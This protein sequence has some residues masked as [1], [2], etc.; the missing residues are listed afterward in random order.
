[1]AKWWGPNGFSN[2]FFDFEFREGGPSNFIM[3]GPDGTNYDNAIV[4]AEIVRHKKIV[5]DHVCSPLFRA[6][7]TFDNLGENT[8]VTFRQIFETVEI[9]EALRPICE[10]AN[11]QN[12]DRITALLA[13][14]SA[15]EAKDQEF[16]IMRIFDAPQTLIYKAWTD[17]AILSSWWGPETFS[18]PVCDLDVRPKGKFRIVMRGLADG[19]T[20]DYPLRGEFGEISPDRIVMIQDATE[21]PSAWHD[22]VNPQRGDN[23][24][25]VG[26][27]HQTV[28]FAESNGRT[29]VTIRSRFETVA[30]R[31]AMERMGMA[32]GWSGSLDRLSQ[33]LRSL[34]NH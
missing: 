8:K 5:L 15:A 34:N 22:M 24:N 18:C 2:T 25:P 12:F 29:T 32:Q 20:P 26:L 33:I 31:E 9:C 3:H 16:V 27:I 4:Y 21:H 14:M 13:E 11:E 10:P 17:P 6:V 1:L 30:I 19:T 7:V 23:P 28:S